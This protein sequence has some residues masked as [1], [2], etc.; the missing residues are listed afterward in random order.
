MKTT[1]GSPLDFL[2]GKQPA[3]F[4]GDYRCSH[5]RLRHTFRAELVNGRSI[6]VF[7]EHGERV[8]AKFAG[9]QDNRTLYCEVPGVG[10]IGGW[11]YPHKALPWKALVDS[12]NKGRLY[13]TTDDLPKRSTGPKVCPHCGGEL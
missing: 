13:R 1:T 6:H 5:R 10:F 9:T 2:R 8:E 4:G 3:A 11:Q 7:D 12:I